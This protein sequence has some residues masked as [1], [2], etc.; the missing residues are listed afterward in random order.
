MKNTAQ[1]VWKFHYGLGNRDI[2]VRFPARARD[3][4]SLHNFH[5]DPP[6]QSVAE[7]IV[8]REKLSMRE[9]DY[10]LPLVQP[11]FKMHEAYTFTRPY[12][13]KVK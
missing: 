6:N 13:F 4:S 12:I 9:A 5:I 10:L 1:P 3:F 11:R 7:V 8:P 2:G